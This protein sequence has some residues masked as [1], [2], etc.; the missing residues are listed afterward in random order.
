MD[1]LTLAA[2]TGG[3]AAVKSA[4]SGVR[5]A[6]ESADDV[7]AIAGHIDT[8][9]KTQG[10]A[11]KRI[12]SAAKNKE[13]KNNKW[14]KFVKFKLKDDGDDET[15]LANVAAAKLA[16]IQAAEDI[17]RLSFEINK[18]FG[19][20]TWQEILDLQ[21]K[22]I[23]DR[24]RQALEIRKKKEEL[25]ERRALGQKALWQKILIEFGKILLVMAFIAGGILL[26]M[27]VKK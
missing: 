5:S 10:A 17:R 25:R 1:P 18:R 20:N 6:L 19:P 21:Q 24:K 15:S 16:E 14:A 3:F 2:V 26:L 13:L 22:R 9:F 7:S 12:E 27:H 4:I 23:E 11:K 8:L